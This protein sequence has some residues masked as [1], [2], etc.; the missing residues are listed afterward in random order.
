MI[1]RGLRLQAACQGGR[2]VESG[3]AGRGGG[4]VILIRFLGGG[5]GGL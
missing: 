3:A 2:D 4:E 5:R 1:L